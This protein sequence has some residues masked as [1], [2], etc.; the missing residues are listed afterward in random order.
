MAR[1]PR[2]SPVLTASLLVAACSGPRGD[3]DALGG[4][5]RPTGMEAVLRYEFERSH[6]EEMLELLANGSEAERERAAYALAHY[7]EDED[8]ARALRK[9]TRDDAPSVRGAAAF[10]LGQLRA[11]EPGNALATKRETNA[12]VRARNDEA[13][14]RMDDIDSR[15]AMFMLMDIEQRLSLGEQIEL[16]TAPHRWDVS[17]M[18]ANGV[19]A[20]LIEMLKRR[21]DSAEERAEVEA[22]PQ[23][24]VAWR[25]L[26]SLQRRNAAR[27]R[28]LAGTE[29][30]TVRE[31]L[32]EGIAMSRDVFLGWARSANERARCFAVRGLRTLAAD[33][34]VQAGLRRALQDEDWRVACEAAIGLGKTPTPENLEVLT[35]ASRHRSKHVRRCA[36]EAMA[37]YD[38]YKYELRKELDSASA[39]ASPSVEAAAIV[40]ATRLFGDEYAAQLE[41]KRLKSDPVVRTGVADAAA[42]LSTELALPLIRD[43]ARDEHLMVAGRALSSLAK[44]DTTEARELLYRYLRHQDNGLR[45]MAL[46]ALEENPRE[47]DLDHFQ[48]ALSSTTGDNIAE[49][50]RFN[51]VQAV[52]SLPNSRGVLQILMEASGSE[53]RFTKE[54]A[55]AQIEARDAEMH[56]NTVPRTEA[57][58]LAELPQSFLAL[59]HSE[60][61]PFVRI[62]TT[63]GAM[64]FELFPSETPFHVYNFLALA[65]RDHYDELEFHRVVPNFVIQG[66][67]T[68]GDGNGGT[69]WFGGSLPAEFSPRKYVRGS[70]GMPRNEDPDSGGSQIF[71]THRPT[72]HLDGRYTL[73]GELREGFDV[74]DAIEVGD[75][76]LDV[77]QVER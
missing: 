1:F 50:V 59:M 29:N 51:V 34:E 47:S 71:V 6:S 9:A 11:G 12:T 54:L 38:D 41:L 15:S 21:A 17:E 28:E 56:V 43:M 39:D 3:A 58:P 53:N 20:R 70:L 18:T 45:L 76:I 75:R 49:E 72:P 35:R 44:H 42:Y 8:I 46:M 40:T 66:G 63:R 73:F 19:D 14:S 48:R 55:E 62:E 10:S 27:A 64:L 36:Y 60:R 68:R 37:A 22:S 77:V 26:F 31:T 13:T 67:D 69:T 74:L 23:I 2:I 65:E 57:L 52:A 25:I 7:S 16:A 32:E 61:N 24:E 4:A 5:A 30:P 33:D